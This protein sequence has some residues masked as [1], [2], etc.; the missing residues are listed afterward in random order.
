MRSVLIGFAPVLTLALACSDDPADASTSADTTGTTDDSASAT[1]TGG[2]TTA[3]MTAGPTSTT[4]DPTDDTSTDPDSSEDGPGTGALCGDGIVSGAEQC[5]CG[6]FPCNESS[7]GGA[8]CLDVTDPLIPGV[9]TGGVLGCNP[10]SCRFDTTA[11]VYCGDEEING[12]EQCEPDED[13]ETTCMALGAGVAGP[14]ICGADCQ[15]DSSACTDCAFV[16][17]FEQ[18]TCPN[19]FSTQ[20][21][22]PGGAASSWSCGEPTVYGLGPGL[23]SPGV[24]GTNLSGPYGA[25]EISAIVSPAIDVSSCTDSGLVMSLRHWRSFGSGG[26]DGGI[27]QVSENG[28]DWTTVAPFGDEDLYGVT[29]LTATYAPVTGSL[30]FDAVDD[31]NSFGVSTFDFSEYAGSSALQVR[32]VFGSDAAGQDGGW[33]IDWMEVL[34]SGK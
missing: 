26:G 5:D 12:N 8:T 22:E 27:V 21:L 20:S 7:L 4:D 25:N 28:V 2:P 15:I 23:S 34:G 16:V 6:G 31:Q 24:F 29:P 32:F 13:I 1:T 17:D 33:Y 14:L 18:S 11:C 19:G 30:G 10:A 3:T 9:I